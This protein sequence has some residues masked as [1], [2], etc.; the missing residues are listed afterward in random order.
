[1][2][3][4]KKTFEN[5][6]VDFR[7]IPF[8][9]WNDKL[10]PDEI[11]R[12]ITEMKEQGMGGFFMHSREGLETKYMSNEWMECI[13]KAV[14]TA[15]YE[16]LRAWLYDEDRWPS[17]AAGGLV[18]EKGGDDFR[19]KAIELKRIKEDFI[20][21]KDLL[22]L[23]SLKF[24][25]NYLKFAERLDQNSVSTLNDDDY[26]IAFERKISCKSEW[27]NNDAP[28][29]SLNPDSVK[30]FI[31]ITYEA[32]KKTVGEEFGR[33]IPGIFTDE[34]GFSYFIPENSV[35]AW[36]D[37]FV[38]IPWTD[39]FERTFM[40]KRGYDF[41]DYIPFIFFEGDN[42]IKVR[43]DFWQTLTEQFTISFSQQIGEWCEANKLNFTGH[44]MQENDLWMA[45]K[46]CGAIM[47]QYEFQ[48]VPGI[49]ILCEQTDE[50][51]TVKQC[52]SVANQFG[53][54]HVL[55][56]TYGCTGWQFTF[57]GQKRIG[58]WQYILG[59][60]LRC[61]HLAL[62]SLRGCRK[63]D[64]P[65]TF[66]YNTCWWKYN[67]VVEDY[68][69]RM[70]LMLSEG[71][72]VRDLLLLHPATTSWALMGGENISKVRALGQDF[73]RLAKV[74]SGM[75][76][77]YDFGDEIIMSK[78]AMVEGALLKVKLAKYKVVLIPAM[79]SLLDS[80]FKLLSD[81][82]DAGG[83]ILSL[84]QLPCLI[85]GQSDGDISDKFRK[86]S[87]HPN[88]IVLDDI[89]KLCLTLEEILPR[90]VSVTDD[91]G[92]QVQSILYMQRA[93]Q[94]RQIYGFVNNNQN[95]VPKTE[96]RLN[97]TGNVEEWDLLSGKTKAV[98]SYLVEGKI[99]FKT[100][101]EPVD[102]KIFV[103][104]KRQMF[105]ERDK[106]EVI[107]P[108]QGEKMSAV[109]IGPEC[110]FSRT[111]PN[112]LTLDKCKYKLIDSDWS[113]TL[114]VW[115]AQRKVREMLGMRQ[116]YRNR[117][118]QR[119]KWIYEKHPGD[120]TLVK[121]LFEFIVL[122]VPL[123]K[124]FAVIE[125]SAE[126]AVFL[127][128]I[129]VGEK[130][131]GWYLDKSFDKIPL[132]GLVQGINVLTL[133]CRYRN[134]LEV[135]DIYI[136][137]DFGVDLHNRSI[138]SEPKTLH[139]GDWCT[140]G[141]PHYCG[142]MIYKGI[143][144]FDPAKQQEKV[145]LT[146]GKCSAVTIEIRINGSSAGHIPWRAADG[147]DITKCLRIGENQIEIEVMGSPRNL[148]GPLHQAAGHKPWTDWSVFRTEDSEYCEGYVLHPYGLMGQ[149][150]IEGFSAR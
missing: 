17:G 87:L 19:A 113:E 89:S 78:W 117:L 14:E 85:E 80:T 48:H 144:R 31:D 4:L 58:D 59:V 62:Y 72:A 47:P 44:L 32:Y 125:R 84:S 1:M 120:G 29:D 57:E 92:M 96:I 108:M 132:I 65:P 97:C 55:S 49:D 145:L 24:E 91:S 100:K 35:S 79:I 8:W 104:N 98:N 23:F 90:E 102:S 54:K 9:S 12:Q 51:L 150:R 64:Y 83:K 121:F 147:L 129:A 136:I 126:F 76:Y 128:N 127:N 36:N 46:M 107:N 119:Y 40:K 15:K 52:T 93:L 86:F 18:P 88:L 74:V 73:N 112:A 28:S 142:S 122:D 61:Q 43:H 66:N 68:F 134:D 70:G 99:A 37:E 138:V 67:H 2:D 3:Q 11:S 103:V 109:F 101:F 140:Q 22:A 30:A 149:V 116:V 111:W 131:E 69:A 6:P 82:L 20:P 33:A 118:P 135:E 81:F 34:P 130:P 106:D 25:G 95:A 27:F 75:H 110:D 139:M 39:G 16:G 26:I 21:H 77:D 124:V 141:Y 105:D 5:P 94:D 143:Y 41:F 42:S 148:L 10:H 56:E 53:R 38:R 115:Q 7:G 63:R 146:I 114:P 133:E 50:F 71:K 137:G 13:K 123:T 45:T 60:T